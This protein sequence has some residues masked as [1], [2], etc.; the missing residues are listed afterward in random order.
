MIGLQRKKVYVLYEFDDEVLQ[1]LD[2]PATGTVELV[3]PEYQIDWDNYEECL[4]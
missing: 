4:V 3:D 1:V 2:Y